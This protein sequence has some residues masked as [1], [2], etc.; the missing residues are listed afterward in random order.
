MVRLMAL[1]VYVA[2]DGLVGYQW[3]E[4][5]LILRRFYAPV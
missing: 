2:D 3:E 5:P 4:M 1:V